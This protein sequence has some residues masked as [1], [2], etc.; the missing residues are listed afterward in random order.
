[1]SEETCKQGLQVERLDYSRPPPGYTVADELEGDEPSWTVRFDGDVVDS[2]MTRERAFAFAWELYKAENDPPGMWIESGGFAE[3][4]LV[5]WGVGH[6]RD[7][8][9]ATASTSYGAARA[10]AWAWHDRRHALA[11]MFEQAAEIMGRPAFPS[12]PAP[13][14]AD[15]LTWSDEQVAA[16]ECWLAGD[17]LKTTRTTMR[18][19]TMSDRKTIL[20][21]A[22]Q[23]KRTAEAGGCDPMPR[24]ASFIRAAVTFHMLTR[25]PWPYMQLTDDR[26]LVATAEPAP[27]PAPVAEPR[28]DEVFAR[29]SA[30]VMMALNIDD[31]DQPS[32]PERAALFAE[33][34]LDG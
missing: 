6:E 33:V 4:D 25:P 18:R 20:K 16:V 29:A 15:M 1:M 19:P 10:A 27:A 17:R 30:I 13:A 34:L 3:D 31:H 24:D 14:W 23:A 2:G 26:R 28:S 11:R 22:R 8:D 9:N 5:F 21:W 7:D 12:D 32:T